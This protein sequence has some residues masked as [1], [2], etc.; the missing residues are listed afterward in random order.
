MT[1]DG[2]AFETSSDFL[3]FEFDS[4]GPRGII[5][6][7]VIYSPLV[8]NPDVYN[9][10]FGDLL[11]DGEIDDEVVSDNGD[12]EIV[13][14]TVIQ[15]LNRFFINRPA[16]GVAFTGSTKSRT[17]LYQI[18]MT[19]SLPEAENAFYLYGIRNGVIEDFVVGL[20]YNAFLLYKRN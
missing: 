19:R 5:R 4:I 1:G 7:A 18:L 17:R 3:R 15:T 8:L 2:Y 6:K 9:L 13:L 11:A 16:K 10:G 14:A 20:N 12:M